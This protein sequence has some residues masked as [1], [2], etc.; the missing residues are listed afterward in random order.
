MASP[1]LGRVLVQG[2]EKSGPAT[3]ALDL[4]LPV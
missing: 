4:S 2:W 1:A 3:G